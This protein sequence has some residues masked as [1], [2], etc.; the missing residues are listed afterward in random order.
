[1]LSSVDAC[2]MSNEGDEVC[3]KRRVARHHDAL[4]NALT[5]AWD[6]LGTLGY[7]GGLG[8]AHALLK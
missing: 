1:M 7:G 3:V 4:S 5:A 2:M 8:P 6:Q